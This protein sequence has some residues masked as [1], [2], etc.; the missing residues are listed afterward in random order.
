MIC[1]NL[2]QPCSMTVAMIVT[3]LSLLA[4]G[5]SSARANTVTWTGLGG[6]GSWTTTTNWDGNGSGTGGVPGTGD[7]VV[8]NNGDTVTA[9]VVLPSSELINL[10]SSSDLTCTSVIRLSNAT[11]NV[12]SGSGL[13]GA[14]WDM[15]NGTLNFSDGAAATMSNWESKG[16]NKFHFDL[17]AS[18]FTTLTPGTYRNDG[19]NNSI[20]LAQKMA[21][22]TYEVDMASYTGG[23]G[24]IILIDYAS[25]ATGL[26][27]AIFQNATLSVLNIPTGL[28]ASLHWIDAT[29]SVVLTI[30]PTPAAL[31]AG[32]AM[33][34]LAAFRRRR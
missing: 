22:S 33:L 3:L 34:G 28:G 17:G 19:N 23:A 30:V 29:D 6:D 14:F 9:N 12:A 10:S 18:G 27:D 32:L 20:T 31:P 7:T 1:R 11:I 25:D 24:T 26:T 16:I 5:V 2:G 21:K 8:I 4:A 13:I 15:N